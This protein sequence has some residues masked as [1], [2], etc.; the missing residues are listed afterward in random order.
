LLRKSRPPN[1]PTNAASMSNRERWSRVA[2]RLGVDVVDLL[3]ALTEEL[4]GGDDDGLGCADAAGARR[5]AYSVGEAALALG[6]SA[7][8]VRS[9]VQ[10]GQL[11]AVRVGR[12]IVIPA[13]ELDRWMDDPAR[14]EEREA[15]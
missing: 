3:V 1:P 6:V 2:D 9:L 12:R 10:R 11:R 5:L 7:D 13:K 14:R 8:L 15:L 4:V